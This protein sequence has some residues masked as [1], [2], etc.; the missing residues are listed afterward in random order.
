VSLRSAN[1]PFGTSPF[2]PGGFVSLDPGSGLFL[3]LGTVNV[4]AGA[5]VFPA[6]IPNTNGLIGRS[7]FFQWVESNAGGT[8]GWLST[9]GGVVFQK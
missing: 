8:Q 1:I 6:S 5:A 9:M 4:A 3:P 7:A 2:T